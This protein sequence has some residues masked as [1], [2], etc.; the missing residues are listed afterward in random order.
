MLAVLGHPVTLRY[1]AYGNGFLGAETWTGRIIEL[2]QVVDGIAVAPDTSGLRTLVHVLQA[3]PTV[4]GVPAAVATLQLLENAPPQ[5]V[6][7]LSYTQTP[8][9]VAAVVTTTQ[10]QL[11]QITLVEEVIPIVAG[12]L[13]VLLIAVG[14]LLLRRRPPTG[15]AKSD[16]RPDRNAPGVELPA[17]ERVASPEMPPSHE[18]GAA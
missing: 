4:P 10:S 2:K 18:Q 17:T 5:K 6:Y 7:Q 13:G 11:G 16:R 3:H 8:A 14:V 15:G 12:V 9:S 1:S